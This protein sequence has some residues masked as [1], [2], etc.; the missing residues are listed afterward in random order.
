MGVTSKY[1]GINWK[2]DVQKYRASV[3]EKGVRYECGYADTEREAAI[4]RD[5]KILALGL[6]SKKLQVLKPFNK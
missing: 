1:S 6:D 2:K 3:T 4:L 5:K